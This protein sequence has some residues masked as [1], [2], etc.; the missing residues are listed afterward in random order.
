ML[1]LDIVQKREYLKSDGVH[2]PICKSEDIDVHDSFHN[3][4]HYYEYVYC[5]CCNTYWT[6]TYKMID[7]NLDMEGRE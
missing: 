1:A 7:V 4:R 3:D 2:C 5:L 6:N